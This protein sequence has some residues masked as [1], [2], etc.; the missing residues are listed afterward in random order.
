MLKDA[1]TSCIRI[2]VGYSSPCLPQA[3]VKFCWCS[4]CLPK[5][6]RNEQEIINRISGTV[7]RLS[8]LRHWEKNV[9]KDRNQTSIL[10]SLLE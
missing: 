3:G 6:G 9:S 8:V 5:A 2:K 7:V 10:S 4:L 1:T